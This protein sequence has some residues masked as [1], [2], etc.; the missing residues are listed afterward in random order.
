MN[1]QTLNLDQVVNR[2][3]V[4]TLKFDD[5]TM[6]SIFGTADLWP[7]WV[8]DMDFQAAPEIKEALSKRLAHGVF[9]YE[10]TSND[11]PN[12]VV[13]WFY[14]RY[15]WNFKA[16]HIITTPRTLNSLAT[17]VSLFSSE[18]DGIIVQP[19]V[20]YDFKLIVRSAKRRLV[21][22]ALKL[23]QG[24]YQ[25]DFN[26]LESVAADAKNTLLIL[27]NPHNPM[28]RVW[29]KK[30]LARLSEICIRNKVFIIADEIH[31][32]IC[33]QHRYTPLASVSEAASLNTASCISPV[34]S[35]NLSGVANSMIVIKDE[36]KRQRCKAWYSRMQ[37]S[38][39]NVFTNAAMLAAYTQGEAWLEQV[40]DY[41]R[42]NLKMLRTFLQQNTPLINLIEPEGSFLVWLDFRALGFDAKQ[43]Q[44]F[45][46]SE[47]K[48]A[49]NP[50]HWF[51]REGAGFARINV[52][53]PRSVLET[54]LT[55]LD[56][57]YTGISSGFKT[58]DIGQD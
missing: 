29:P 21:K 6:R 52:A 32:D 8:A 18:G 47:A 41:L 11:L 35:F 14:R 53:C 10:A 57:A 5:E 24:Q 58:N 56:K 55:N 23:E 17:L 26:G 54:A 34:K 39:N 50:G 51:G 22:N 30:D 16:D 44:S 27:C 12:A 20:F 49:T 33:F 4:R 2:S 42:G 43:L 36:E 40:T 28:G 3:D 13:S 7:S 46:V 9:G 1:S 38:K 19:P 45:L 48:M 31:G 15:S 37:I 25:M